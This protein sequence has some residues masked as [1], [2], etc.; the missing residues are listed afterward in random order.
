MVNPTPPIYQHIPNSTSQVTTTNEN[1]PTSH[2]PNQ[3]TTPS[4]TPPALP[5]NTV[6]PSAFQ[7]PTLPPIPLS[8]NNTLPTQSLPQNP[9][10]SSTHDP[11]LFNQNPFSSSLPPILSI[12]QTTSSTTQSTSYNPYLSLYPTFQNFP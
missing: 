3:Y 8:L 1:L 6:Q 5:Y 9:P 4:N 2:S 12:S 10:P 7:I 11:S